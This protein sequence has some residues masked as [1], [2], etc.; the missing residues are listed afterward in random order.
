MGHRANEGSWKEG[1]QEAMEAVLAK[2]AWMGLWE[3]FSEGW[4]RNIDGGNSDPERTQAGFLHLFCE[5][6]PW[7]QIV[8]WESYIM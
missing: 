6:H 2:D 8:E 1:E 5:D 7:N 3:S 4:P